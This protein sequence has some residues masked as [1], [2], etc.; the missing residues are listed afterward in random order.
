MDG[1]GATPDSTETGFC[2]PAASPPP[3]QSPGRARTSP[4]PVWPGPPIRCSQRR[5]HAPFR[6]LPDR[7]PDRMPPACQRPGCRTGCLPPA[8]LGAG[9]DASRLQETGVPQAGSNAQIRSNPTLK[10][11][12]WPPPVG[13]RL[14]CVDK[15]W[16][17]GV[18]GVSQGVLQALVG[19]P[20]VGCRLWW[21]LT[22]WV[23]GF[24]CGVQRV[25]CRL[26]CGLTRWVAGPQDPGPAPA[27]RPPT[28]Y[29]ARGQ[30]L[31]RLL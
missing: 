20:K 25:C 12:L 1:A 7:V 29:M 15:G 19:C 31:T 13:C 6:G 2:K 24:W 21:G 8:R 14:R 18:G 9:P 11:S 30:S 10:F 16:V 17:A 23:A 22:R 28:V 26:W 5:F 27:L 4:T 3:L